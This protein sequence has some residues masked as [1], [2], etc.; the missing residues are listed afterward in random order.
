[1]AN[2]FPSHVF[3]CRRHI[4]EDNGKKREEKIYVT[5]SSKNT[6]YKQALMTSKFAEDCDEVA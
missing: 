3:L 6:N 2:D 5:S 1:M 4:G